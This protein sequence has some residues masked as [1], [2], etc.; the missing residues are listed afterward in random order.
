MVTP[1]DVINFGLIGVP[2]VFPLTNE[3]I[4]AEYIA[5][6]LQVAIASL[7]M[8]GMLLSPVICHHIDDFTSDGLIGT[9]FFPTILKKYPVREI[10]SI[11]LLFPNATTKNPTLKY[12]IPKEWITFENNKVNVIA[13][14][15][16]LSP[17][18]VAGSTT[19]PYLGLFQGGYKPS[20]YRVNYRAGFDQ[21][22]LPVL[23]WQLILDITTFSLLTDLAPLMFPSQGIS[24]GI[25]SVSQSAQ[26]PGPRIFDSRLKSLREKI[27]T[28]KQI[29]SGYY[30]SQMTMEFAGI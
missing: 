19:V 27:E 11:E 4:N 8:M 14:T 1:Q 3:P 6:Y 26:L 22:Q 10:E 25:D 30:A 18:M 28:Q 23:V 7:E 13:T 16:V 5:Q 29:I 17:T 2:K 12:V 21:D 15:G 9:R 20:S 24:V